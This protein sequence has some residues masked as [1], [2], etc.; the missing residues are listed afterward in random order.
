MDCRVVAAAAAVT[1]HLFGEGDGDREEEAGS[2]EDA[3]RERE[4]DI[5][6]PAVGA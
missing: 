3:K 4:A 5:V 2:M 6:P 1:S